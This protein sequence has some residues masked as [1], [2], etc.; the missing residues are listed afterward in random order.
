MSTD[1]SVKSGVLTG[2][3]GPGGDVVIPESVTQIGESAFSDCSGLASITIPRGVTHIGDSAFEDCSDLTCITIPEGVTHIGAHAFEGCSGLK[4]ITI[5][6]GVTDIGICAFCGCSD[7]SR[8]TIPKS[9]MHIGSGAFG[10]TA[11]YDDASMW[12]SGVLYL[13]NHLIEAKVDK[14]IGSY[15]IR[16]GTVCIG[17]GAFSGCTSL[18]DVEFIEGLVNIGG[19]AF[20]IAP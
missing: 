8:I 4:S 7:L 2:Y 11:L 5:P 6:E 13:G 18:T 17:D 1:F 14:L 15:A 3:T 20:S 9:V 19:D 16:P 10:D 12:E